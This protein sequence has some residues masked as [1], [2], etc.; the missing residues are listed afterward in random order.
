MSQ[1]SFISAE[2]R[3]AVPHIASRM[4]AVLA[5]AELSDIEFAVGRE[6]GEAKIFPAHKFALSISS[7]VFYTMFHGSLAKNNLDIIQ[8]PE[9]LPEAFANMLSYIYTD[10]VE[11]LQPENVLQTLYC[12]DKYD[13][14][15]LADRC[16][17]FILEQMKPDTC[18]MF[19]ENALR[20]TP[21]CDWIVEKC[22]DVVDE[23]S[24][25]V[26]QSKQFSEIGQKTLEMILRRDTLSADE[27]VICG[28]VDKWA[29]AACTR[30]NKPHSAAN[31]RQVLGDALF[32]IR[33]PLLTD[34]QLTK[35]QI[36]CATLLHE[37]IY[38]IYLFKHGA[39]K[40]G[41]QFPIKPRKYVT[42]EFRV[43]SMDDSSS[44]KYLSCKPREKI[45]ILYTSG[46]WHPAV[47]SGESKLDPSPPSGLKMEIPVGKF[48]LPNQIACAVDLLKRGQQLF[49]FVEGA[50]KEATYGQLRAGRHTVNV[51]GRE[52]NV[53]FMQL[54]F[55]GKQ[56][57]QWKAAKK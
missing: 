15:W 36:K 41:L 32:L 11:N 47:V 3:G 18:L 50:F 38:R 6:H 40:E 21:D 8:V 22:L 1:S 43:A 23:S 46:Y 9:I 51:A 24:M 33:F 44:Y 17:S 54:K 31:R 35:G 53:D 13:L 4:K 56:I 14:P 5:N 25:A 16:T 7:D 10:S 20:W 26:L 30:Q 39:A 49:A 37:E 42:H 55:S 29:V 48:A 2:R 28:A 34:E 27:N 19:L 45:F 57:E 52:Y 12:A